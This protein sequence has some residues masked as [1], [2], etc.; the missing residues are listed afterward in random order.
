MHSLDDICEEYVH[1]YTSE[2]I[3]LLQ[4]W[5]KEQRKHWIIY[6]FIICKQ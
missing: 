5:A 1:T 2:E 3:K 6:N 4:D